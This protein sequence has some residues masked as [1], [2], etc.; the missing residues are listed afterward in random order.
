M[1]KNTEKMLAKI[2]APVSR[3]V[4]PGKIA[5]SVLLGGV[6]LLDFL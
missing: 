6:F 1:T 3:V 2:H 5:P 4:H